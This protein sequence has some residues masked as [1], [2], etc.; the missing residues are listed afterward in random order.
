MHARRSVPQCRKLGAKVTLDGAT[1]KYFYYFSVVVEQLRT[2]RF[3]FAKTPY[4][5]S[6]PGIVE[7]LEHVR[8]GNAQQGPQRAPHFS[9]KAVEVVADEV[10]DVHHVFVVHDDFES[11]RVECLI[12]D[13]DVVIN[14][15]LTGEQS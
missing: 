2:I 11:T 4:K 12:S 9:E 6:L 14:R 8:D 15:V 10:I 3:P 1:C 5:E 13:Q 7:E